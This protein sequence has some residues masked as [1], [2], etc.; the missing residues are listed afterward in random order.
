MGM[1]RTDSTLYG[2][3]KNNSLSTNYMLVVYGSPRAPT[4][5]C[6]WR[7]IEIRGDALELSSSSSV[8]RHRLLGR[9]SRQEQRNDSN[10][11]HIKRN[12]SR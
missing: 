10:R 7:C 5:R 9:I 1:E 6:W 12:R 4:V 8:A 3:S 11:E 2:L